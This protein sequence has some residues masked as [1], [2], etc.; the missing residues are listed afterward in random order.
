[1]GFVWSSA[2][3]LLYFILFYKGA[4]IA[5]HAP[6]R[7]GQLLAVGIISWIAI[8]AFLNIGGMINI[9]P[10][11]G[12]PLPLVSYGGSALASALLALGILVNI[13]KYTRE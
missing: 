10:M 5:N 11:T 9:I 8:Q 2:L 3:I 1:M 4:V 12:V 6:D 13:S 7:F